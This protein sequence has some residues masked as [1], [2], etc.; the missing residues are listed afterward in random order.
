MN[1]L[2]YRYGSVCEPHVIDAFTSLGH[3]IRT[4][5]NEITDSGQPCYGAA[6]R[7]SC[8]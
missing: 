2:F 3:Y 7:Y 4:I 1:F 6:V 8:Q 5:E